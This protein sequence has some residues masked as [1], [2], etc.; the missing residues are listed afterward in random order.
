MDRP[1]KLLKYVEWEQNGNWYCNDTSDLCSVRAKWWAPARMLNISP[2]EFVQL[3][4]NDFHPDKI[5]YNQEAN[6]LV[7]S[8][9]NINACRAF[10]NWLNAQARKHNFII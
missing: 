8:W 7:Y 1:A 9:K 10:K 3:L 2:A 5:K 6:V 4:I